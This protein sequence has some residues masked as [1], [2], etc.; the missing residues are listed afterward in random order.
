MRCKTL[1]E[2]A[3]TEEPL[4]LCVEG[5]LR[6]DGM[7]G[8]EWLVITEKRAVV[9]AQ[10]DGAIETR[11]DIPLSEMTDPKAVSFVGGG[12]L[13]V[14][15]GV[16]RIELIRYTHAHLSS[17]GTA[18]NLLEKWLKGEPAAIPEEDERRCPSCGFPMEVG[19]R[20][21]PNCSPRTRT[22]RRLIGYLKPH[23]RAAVGLSLLALLDMAIGLIPPYLSKPLMD[24]VLAPPR[25]F[26]ATDTLPPRLRL[27]GL[28][29]LAL[30]A[31]RVMMGFVSTAQSWLSAWLGNRITHDI[32]GT[33]YRHLQYLSLSFFDKRQ[34]GTVISRINQDTGQ[35]QQFLVWGSQE[36]LTNILLV[37]GI[38]VMLLVMNWRLALLVMLAIPLV[39]VISLSFWKRIRRYM[40][41]LFQRWG[42]VNAVLSE[43]LTG[44]KIVKAF[45]QE[46]REIQRFEERSRDLAVAGTQAERM[47]ATL[48]SGMSL[49]IMLG[50]LL[51]W[52]MGG[53]D[54]LFGHMS[55]GTFIAFLTYV[56][57]VYGPVQHLSLLLNWSSRSLTAAER[58]FEILDRKPEVED[59]EKAIPMPAIRGQVEFRD[60]TFGYDVH[61][62]VLKKVSFAIEPGEMIGLV[63]H[64]GAGKSTMVSLLCR[65]YEASE[66][67][68]LIDGVP[69]KRIRLEDVRRQIGL[70]PQEAFL[71]SGTIAENI[72]YAKP[73]ATREEIIRAARIAN[74]HDFIRR[75]PDGYET[76]VG[77]G[78]QGLSAGEKQRVAIARA[79]LHGPKILILD[80]AT[81][82]IDV[83]TEK[84]IQEAIERLARGRTTF[85]IAHRLSTLKNAQRLIVLKK[86]EIVEIGTHDELM[87]KEDGEF[88][89]L[90]K[91]YQEI[92]RVQAIQR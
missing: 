48:F 82:Q 30:L 81:S 57:M 11:R 25:G 47:W 7:F 54:V 8:R 75:K 84:Q 29:V 31:V 24:E 71:F 56:G 88:H 26:A 43:S 78:G 13:E 74:A 9:L 37:I 17:F 60:L 22:L 52:Y 89:K 15:R 73:G 49:L 32:R 20:V 38:G 58:V 14:T 55:L 5:D 46:R 40:K 53:R 23:R 64:S 50:T 36:L 41:R 91:A 66:G 33:L 85:A 45:A 44:L 79:V 86:G 34:M 69:L 77:E 1:P 6:P 62:P 72:A 21:C 80:E 59:Q 28:L 39:A 67:E 76:F 3:K 65:F 87:A 16:E 83:E 90:V 2:G 4:R 19:S 63:G 68:I 35:L 51:V 70:V 42:R 27:L 92:S 10:R 61:Q 18:A 12:A